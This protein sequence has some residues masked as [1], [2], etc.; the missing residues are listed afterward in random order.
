MTV[1]CK[2]Y[3]NKKQ[4]NGIDIIDVIKDYVIDGTNVNKLESKYHSSRNR[5]IELLKYIGVLR[6]KSEALTFT[7]KRNE[8]LSSFVNIPNSVMVKM[9][10]SGVNKSKLACWFNISLGSKAFVNKI[11]SSDYD[12]HY[13]KIHV[14]NMSENLIWKA[15]Y[16]RS[17]D[18]SI[19]EVLSNNFRNIELSKKMDISNSF[20]TCLY[21]EKG[22][23]ENKGKSSFVSQNF[24]NNRKLGNLVY[25]CATSKDMINHIISSFNTPS[26]INFSLFFGNTVNSARNILNSLNITINDSG[27]YGSSYEEKVYNIIQRVFGSR[28][29]IK[30]WDRSI[31]RGRELDFYLP[32]QHIAIE[33]SPSETHATGGNIAMNYVKPTYHYFKRQQ[34]NAKGI[35]LITLPD[36][37]L[38]DKFIYNELP[39]M[40]RQFGNKNPIELTDNLIAEEADRSFGKA[41]VE[42]RREYRFN[43]NISKVINISMSDKTI[44]TAILGKNGH[45]S[46]D[47]SIKIIDIFSNY[48]LP[49]KSELIKTLVNWIKKNINNDEMIYA[50]T[51]YWHGTGSYLRNNGF[52]FD[53]YLKSRPIYVKTGRLN[54]K[55]L[56]ENDVNKSNRDNYYQTGY[57][58]M[59]NCG[60]SVYR[61]E[62]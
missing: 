58:E 25:E 1:S 44:A 56:T 18:P 24:R 43:T 8:R 60:A 54:E 41:L 26:I 3:W 35:N 38:S 48:V 36:P 6:N 16:L 33:V 50:V 28:T 9:A 57:S 40:L 19:F 12:N 42:N 53:H 14:K 31:L 51:S 46:L 20:L 23:N 4:L 45:D 2:D 55:V 15:K 62:E 17:I 5:V 27:R 29:I 10:E 52:V 7:N 37:Q 21:N 39:M 59:Y 30:R 32:K 61:Y 13:Q 11:N 47:K 34:C 22:I 49:S